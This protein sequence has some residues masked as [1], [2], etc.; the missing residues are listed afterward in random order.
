[1]YGGLPSIKA[2]DCTGLGVYT[3]NDGGRCCGKCQE[4]RKRRGGSNPGTHL[5]NWNTTITRALERGFKSELT[6][7][8][9]QEAHNF[10]KLQSLTEAGDELKEQA[11]AQVEYADY[12]SRL[13][14]NLPSKSKRYKLALEG[15]VPGMNALFEDVAYLC[16]TNKTFR[17]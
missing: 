7:T 10:V 3:H 13:D 11:R 12:M 6:R 5:N 8:D 16:R 4:L 9:I 15:S 14:K 2:H 1:M 17:D